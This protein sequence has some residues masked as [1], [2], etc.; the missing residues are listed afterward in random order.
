[1]PLKYKTNSRKATQ[2]TEGFKRE[3]SRELLRLI[4]T[5]SG[6][7]QTA[8][9]EVATSLAGVRK[10]SRDMAI[11]DGYYNR[12]VNLNEDN[13]VGHQGINLSINLQNKAVKNPKPNTKESNK[14]EKAWKD[15]SKTATTD[16]QLT[17]RDAQVLFARTR[18]VDGEVFY[19]T[20]ID[21][22]LKDNFGIQFIEADHFDETFDKKLPNGNT[23][24]SSI[25]F[26]NI[27]RIVAYH[28]TETHPQEKVSGN[29][30][31]RRIEA[32]KIRHAFK[33]DRIS[34]VRGIPEGRA[35]WH[36]H[37]DAE[38]MGG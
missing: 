2:P 8:H 19:Q 25:E 32:I 6:G 22:R 13:V 20:V 24:R 34:Q 37:V 33:R 23:I 29:R 15:W 10:A 16:G 11:T 28:A 31:I 5:N 35:A 4:N 17:F 1:M 26:D 38:Q 30:K 7:N 9:T 18:E 36:R 3:I 27:G 21:G 12:F 14:I